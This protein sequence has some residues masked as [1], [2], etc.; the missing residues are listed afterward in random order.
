[1][2]SFGKFEV[3]GPGALDLL[4]RVA[5]NNI[6][7]PDGSLVY[8][9]FLNA[10]GGIESDLTVCRLACDRFSHHHRHIVFVERP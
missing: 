9:Q 8:T 3:S 7:R 2:T 10:H 5:C 4:Q 6:D 1:M